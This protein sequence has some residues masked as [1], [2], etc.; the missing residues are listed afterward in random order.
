MASLKAHSKEC[1][2]I[3]AKDN[4]FSSIRVFSTRSL[5][6]CAE[7][8]FSFVDCFHISQAAI[9]SSDAVMEVGSGTGNLTVRLLDRAKVVYACELDPRMIAELQ[10]RVVGT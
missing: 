2:L 9:Q 5:K 4:T 8:L 6:R 10:K 3:R 7:E 1:R